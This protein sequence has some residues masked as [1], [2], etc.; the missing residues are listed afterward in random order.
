MDNM[1][2][3]PKKEKK[4]LKVD[5]HLRTK[6]HAIHEIF[7][8]TKTIVAFLGFSIGGVLVG[9]SI[10]EYGTQYLSLEYTLLIGMLIF[11]ISG[12]ILHKFNK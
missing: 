7:I 3:K 9:R 10:W 12:I 8:S 4:G 5:V 11:I 2:F 1:F 6:G